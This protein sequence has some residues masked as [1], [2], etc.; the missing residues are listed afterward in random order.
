VPYGERKVVT[1][2]ASGVMTVP[3]RHCR[4]YELAYKAMLDA[5][6][7]VADFIAPASAAE[8]LTLVHGLFHHHRQRI[9]HAWIETPDGHV[10]DVVT[11]QRTPL[12]EYYARMGATIERRYSPKEAARLMLGHGHF[13]PWPAS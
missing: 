5:R 2:S 9:P 4:C 6:D 7:G 12:D 1:L 10:F 11:D 8:R 13:G 3:R